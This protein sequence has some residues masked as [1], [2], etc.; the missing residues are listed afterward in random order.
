MQERSSSLP[1]VNHPRSCRCLVRKTSPIGTRSHS[2]GDPAP[3]ADNESSASPTSPHVDASSWHRSNDHPRSYTHS[4][5]VEQLVAPSLSR[6]STW[7]LVTPEPGSAKTTDDSTVAED[8]GN[9]SDETSA[10]T[11]T[12]T[13]T[14]QELTQLIQALGI[15]LES[16]N[17]TDR[18]LVQGSPR[19]A[20]TTT[21]TTGLITDKGDRRFESVISNLAQSLIL[22]HHST[23]TPE[24][25]S[26]IN[27]RTPL[28]FAFENLVE[29][30]LKMAQLEPTSCDYA[31]QVFEE[32][33]PFDRATG[34][35]EA[36]RQT[37][38][39]PPRIES[40]ASKTPGH[41]RMAQHM[42]RHL[43][44]LKQQIQDGFD[45]AQ[46]TKES[47]ARMQAQMESEAAAREKLA[48]TN[49]LILARLNHLETKSSMQDPYQ[50]GRVE[51]TLRE[52]FDRLDAKMEKDAEAREGLAMTNRLLLARLNHLESSVVRRE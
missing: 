32:L 13:T 26:P 15:Q 45:E 37:C 14:R 34:V 49:R 8:E 41:S 9:A 10:T 40:S 6:S 51:Q 4:S 48:T 36:T 20:V 12:T 7:E 17:T 35:P 50:L 5:H 28:Q 21:T 16:L 3:A 2:A 22:H 23:V 52:R 11:A 33:V 38:S 25:V 44:L 29:L 39:S 47:S 42:E 1:Q 46:R 18:P 24:L 30:G 19:K 27:A 31:R 43:E